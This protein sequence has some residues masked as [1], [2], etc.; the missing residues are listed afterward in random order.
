MAQRQPLEEL[1][2]GR[3]QLVAGGAEA[4]A[5]AG[6][7]LKPFPSPRGAGASLRSLH[8]RQWGCRGEPSGAPLAASRALLALPVLSVFLQ[9]LQV[10]PG[11]HFA[12]GDTGASE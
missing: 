5:P 12:G 8:R 4:Q 7:V 3:G 11:A 2:P 10:G 9:P 6:L 1:V